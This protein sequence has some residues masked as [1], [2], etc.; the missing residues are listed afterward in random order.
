MDACVLPWRINTASFEKR[1]NVMES[2][3]TWPTT[4][5]ENPT[6]NNGDREAECGSEPLQK[7]STKAVGTSG[8]VNPQLAQKPFHKSRQDREVGGHA[9]RDWEKEKLMALRGCR[10]LVNPGFD[11][12]VGLHDRGP[13]PS[14]RLN[15]QRGEQSRRGLSV[16]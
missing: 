8:L 1:H 10:A 4:F 7:Q 3:L 2:P 5:I 9:V 13:A 14:V 6:G 11:K 15:L 12:R 16:K